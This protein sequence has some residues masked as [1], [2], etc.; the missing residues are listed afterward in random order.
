M[1]TNSRVQFLP[2]VII[3]ATLPAIVM[4]AMRNYVPTKM[5]AAAMDVS[6]GLAIVGL[7]WMIKGRRGCP[8]DI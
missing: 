4:P 8:D 1:K 2:I 5:L 7:G 3:P 6:I